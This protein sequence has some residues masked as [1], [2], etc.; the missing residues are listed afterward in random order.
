M[1]ISGGGGRRRWQTG[2]TLSLSLSLY[3]SLSLYLFLSL[4]TSLSL[5]LSRSPSLAESSHV[6]AFTEIAGGIVRE[7]F[8]F[9]SSF[10][11]FSF[12]HAISCLQKPL[13]PIQHQTQGTA[14][15]F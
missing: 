7:G 14:F 10:S 15:M 12:F 13:M 4:S 3:P 5:S 9:F 11:L 6:Y 1:L 2:A 8:N